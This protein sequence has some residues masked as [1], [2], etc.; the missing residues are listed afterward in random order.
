V[1]CAALRAATHTGYAL[2]VVGTSG[3][4]AALLPLVRWVAVLH[5]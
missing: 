2:N 5:H 3:K 4:N 1:F